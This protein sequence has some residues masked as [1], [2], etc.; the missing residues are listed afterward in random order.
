MQSILD[1]LI[2]SRINNLLEVINLNYPDKFKKEEIK[3]EIT[4]IKKNIFWKKQSIE[5]NKKLKLKLKGKNKSK[6]KNIIKF[7]NTIDTIDTIDKNTNQC[8]G[9]VWSKYILDKKNM[10]KLN[11]ID[12]KFKVDDFIDID[13][14]EFNSKY[15]IGSRCS[16]KKDTNIC[17]D[18]NK[19]CKLHEKHLIHGDYLEPPNKEL[20]FHFMKD[21][22]YL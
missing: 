6:K 9:R 13:I 4:Y 2:D 8:S 7:K 5:Q 20:C 17:N 16:K 10:N 15:I 18:T 1:K 14:K 12:D 3:K 21:A 11:D 19:Y 22:K